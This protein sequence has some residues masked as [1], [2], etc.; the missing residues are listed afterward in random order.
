MRTAGAERMDKLG[1]AERA[2]G[3]GDDESWGFYREVEVL[4]YRA[5]GLERAP[6]HPDDHVPPFNAPAPL[7]LLGFRS[8]LRENPSTSVARQ[9][10]MQGSILS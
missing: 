5:G 7:Q 1:E 9:L 2:H 6:V 8:D 3:S 4:G 10:R